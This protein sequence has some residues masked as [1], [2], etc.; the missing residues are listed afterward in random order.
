MLE[1]RYEQLKTVY[2][3]MPVLFKSITRIECLLFV[4][5]IAIIIQSLIERDVRMSMKNRGIENIPAIFRGRRMLFVNMLP[6]LFCI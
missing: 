5:F 1:K 2:N 3:V 6:H 4:Y